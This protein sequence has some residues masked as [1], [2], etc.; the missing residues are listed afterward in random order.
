MSRP[1]QFQNPFYVL[2]LVVGLLFVVTTCGY[3]VMTVR[4]MDP[5]T[6][7]GAASPSGQRLMEF[8]DRYGFLL[9][10]VELAILGAA[11]FAAIATD[12]Y[13]MRRQVPEREQLDD[14]ERRSNAAD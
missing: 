9:L 6:Q 2:L 5:A 1:K 4:G 11:T 8:F 12:H 7:V 14:G 10:I 13:W 3:A